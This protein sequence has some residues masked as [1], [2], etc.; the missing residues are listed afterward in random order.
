MIGYDKYYY[1]HYCECPK[2]TRV[3]AARVSVIHHPDVL[4]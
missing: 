3:H 2:S 1:E 4:K